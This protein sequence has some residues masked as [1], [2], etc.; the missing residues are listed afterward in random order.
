M[1]EMD[2]RTPLAWLSTSRHK[3]SRISASGSPLATISKIRL[4]T[5]RMD[6][7]LALFVINTRSAS[8]REV[9]FSWCGS[10]LRK[11]RRRNS[12]PRPHVFVLRSIAHTLVLWAARRRPRPI[13]GIQPNAFCGDKPADSTQRLVTKSTTKLTGPPGGVLHSNGRI[14]LTTSRSSFRLW[15]KPRRRACAW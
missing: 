15:R 5:A 9:S 8:L 11:N 12:P 10:T 2:A 1:N 6:S 14:A 13:I 4:S 3:L 7:A